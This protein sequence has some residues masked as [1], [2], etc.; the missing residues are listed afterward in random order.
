MLNFLKNN[1][2]FTHKIKLERMRRGHMV[3]FWRETAGF[4]HCVFSAVDSSLPICT[5]AETQKCKDVCS[6]LSI[7]IS[8]MSTKFRVEQRTNTGI[9]R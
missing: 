2:H 7:S 5:L 9:Y 1:E 4:T 8:G 3:N 6:F